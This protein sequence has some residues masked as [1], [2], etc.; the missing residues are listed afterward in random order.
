MATGSSDALDALLASLPYCGAPAT[1]VDLWQR[2]NLDPWLIATFAA[3]GLA[4]GWRA[5]RRSDARAAHRHRCFAAGW[6]VALLALISP[7]CA[8]SVALFSVRVGQHMLLVLLAAPLLAQGLPALR[9][10]PW[11]AGAAFF[12]AL[13]LWHFP[14]LYAWSLRNDL[15]YWAMQAGLIASAVALWQAVFARDGEQAAR[16]AVGIASS[17]HM[18][19]LGA[20]LTFASRPFYAAH[21]LTTNSWGLSPL[22]DQQLAGLLMWVPGGIV[23]GVLGLVGFLVWWKQASAAQALQAGSIGARAPHGHPAP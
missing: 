6:A 23:F 4:Y 2:W 19:L 20:L 14:P 17:V 21:R 22:A 9:I 5:R 1:P 18:G 7:L 15:V 10:R 13:W 16:I 11:A 3:I 12:L 8:W